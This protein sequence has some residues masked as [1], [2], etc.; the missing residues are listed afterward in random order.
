MI[1]DDNM[2][3]NDKPLEDKLLAEKKKWLFKENIRLEELRKSLEDER[4]LLDIQRGMFEKQQ[5]KN[6][7]LEKQLQNQKRLFDRQWQILEKETRQLAIDKE[8]FER[9][10]RVYRDEIAREVRKGMA[11]SSGV[12]IFFKGVD[13]AQ[14]LKKRYRELLKI[15]HPDNVNGDNK[16]LQAIIDEYELSLIHI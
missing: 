12:K 3:E 10:K 4:E 8:K 6:A 9:N 1:G 13:N 2:P 16:L 11:V 15:Y 7:I 5:R 14:N